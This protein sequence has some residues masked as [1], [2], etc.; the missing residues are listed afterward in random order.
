MS[1]KSG[2]DHGDPFLLGQGIAIRSI[3][4]NESLLDKVNLQLKAIKQDGSF[5]ILYERYL[6]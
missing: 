6:Q 2:Q 3:P 4:F 5:L 1:D